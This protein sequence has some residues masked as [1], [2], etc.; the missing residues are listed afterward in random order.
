MELGVKVL[1]HPS[2]LY[3]TAFDWMASAL[4]VFTKTTNVNTAARVVGIVPI[5]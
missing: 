1:S 5:F 4:L 2:I 3:L